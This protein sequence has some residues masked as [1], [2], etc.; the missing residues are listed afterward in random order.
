MTERVYGQSDEPKTSVALL[1]PVIKIDSSV[2][3]LSLVETP[4]LRGRMRFATR[5]PTTKNE[6]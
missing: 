6:T 2:H 5:M 1:G 4:A 3:A